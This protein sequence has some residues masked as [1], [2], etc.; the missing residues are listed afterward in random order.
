V[1]MGVKYKG[2]EDSAVS[3]YHVLY[4]ELKLREGLFIVKIVMC[5]DEAGK[6][7]VRGRCCLFEIPD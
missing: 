4:Y 1:G 3:D 7:K 6:T 2:A 5:I